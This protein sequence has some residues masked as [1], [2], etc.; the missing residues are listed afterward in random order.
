MEMMLL[1]ITS[2][3]AALLY[4]YIKIDEWEEK[5]KIEIA[6]LFLDFESD[7]QVY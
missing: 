7:W 5:K 2:W 6:Y 4:T 3:H 1:P